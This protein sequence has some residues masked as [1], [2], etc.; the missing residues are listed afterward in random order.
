[1]GSL[2]TS[3]SGK[4]FIISIVTYSLTRALFKSMLFD[5]QTFG[6]IF[7]YLFAVDFLKIMT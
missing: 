3:L 4:Y 1:M 7:Q 5:F 6:G 2:F